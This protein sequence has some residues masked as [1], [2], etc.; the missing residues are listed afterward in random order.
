M[1]HILKISVYILLGIVLLLYIAFLF[2]IP[3]TIDL[4]VYKPQIQKLIK[5]NTDLTLD[6]DKVEVIT[7]P[8]LEGGIKAKNISVNLPDNSTIF[9][10]KSAKGKVFLP[11]LL[12]LNIKVTCAEINSPK[13]NIEIED[14]QQFKVAKVYENL[15]NKQRK[16]RLE[17]N[18]RIEENQAE[19]PIDPAK[20]KL[21]IPNLKLNNYKAVINDTSAKHHLALKGDELKIGYFNG[22]SAKLKT[23]AKLFSDNNTNITANIDI[24]TFI[25]EFS[26]QE[27]EQEDD[28]AIFALPFTNPVS[29]YRKYDLKSNINTKLKIRQD[30]N[31]KKIKMN[32]Y[33]NIE[34]TTMNLAGLQ[35]PES[36]FKLK[37]KD[38][39]TEIDTNIYVTDKEYINLT[40]N[41]DYGKNPYIDIFLKSPQVHFS[42]ILNIAKAYLNTIHIQ[43]DLGNITASGYMLSN[44]H[45]KT[46]FSDIISAGKIIIRDGNISDKNIGLLF[47]DIHANLFFDNNIFKV[48]NTHILINNHPL[49]ISG[50]IDSNSIANFNIVGDKIPLSGLYQVFAPRNIKQKFDLVSGNLSIDSKV[51][52]EIKDIA[53]ILKADL[54]N[55]TFKDKAGT[56]VLANKTAHFGIANYAGKIR[57][58]LVNKGFKF[59]LPQTNAVISDDLFETNIDNKT[60]STNESS[61]K[62]NK[63]SIFKLNATV[64][65]YITNPETKL[66]ADGRFAASDIAI[67]MGKEALPYFDI[68]GTIPVKVKLDG[69]NNRQKLIIQAKTDA[70]NYI[71][72]ITINELVGKHTLFQL[73]LVNNNDT[74]KINKSGIY[75]TSP[76]SGF[77]NKLYKNLAGANP[78]VEIRGII[79]SISTEPFI[80]LLK[81]SIS[82]KLN[83]S[84]CIFKKSKFSTSGNI[85]AFG[86][87]SNPKINGHIDVRD[88]EIPEIHTAIRHAF[89]Q[90]A[91]KNIN[92]GINDVDAN[93]SDF[94]ISAT[95]NLELISKMIMSDIKINSRFINIDKLMEVSNS[96]MTTLPK[97]SSANTNNSH[98]NANIPLE[99]KNG[100]FKFDK[101]KTGDIIANNTTGKLFLKNNILHVNNIKTRPLGGI[102]TGNAAM[103]LITTEL[104]MRLKGHDFDIEKVLADA[105]QMKDTLTGNMNFIADLSLKGTSY[106]EQMKTLKGFVDFNIQDG[107][108]GPFGKFENF[109]MAENIRENAFFS[110]AVGSIITNLVTI[111]TAHFNNLYGHLT[112]KDGLANIEP[113]KSQGNVMSIYIAGK[114]NLLD[115]SADMKLRGKLASAFSDKLGPLAN[116]NPI[117]L[118][119]NTPGLNI[120]AA[121]TFA[122]FCQSVSEEEMKAIPQLAKDRSDENATKFQ[123]ILRGDTRKP[124]KMIK[125]FKWLA[126]DSEIQ[127]A[128]D[129]VDTL[130]VHLEGEE[131]LSVE[132]LIK[133]RQEQ[134]SP[135]QQKFEQSEQVNNNTILKKVKSKLK[136]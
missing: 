61:I 66:F 71:T 131:N 126:L 119:K 43:N 102:V 51:T 90:L 38:Y 112:F 104:K 99:I 1:K 45:F 35:L 96:L 76:T 17:N 124:L 79:S 109:L 22:K 113:I 116:I 83:G 128:R 78:I 44:A 122:I 120:V 37:A 82:K 75:T 14:S 15:V 27:T 63:N 52:G 33:A 36:Y 19:L 118:V 97:T 93:G 94:N 89:I 130:P 42:N 67:F 103:N 117:N 135:P 32:G 115:N 100:S 111:D 70:K 65:N 77:S 31:D 92:I 20:I 46:D 81:I 7:S 30:K 28:E 6:F 62:I 129:F 98:N 88:I 9:F 29:E 58:K 55:F 11:S 40:G 21:Y 18:T 24:D 74:L 107:T 41:I 69:K 110:S 108:L 85:F 72:P 13:L 3:K 68:K 101:I 123:I 10:A 106:E 2:I 136:K 16:E 39:Y 26:P 87:I 47:N 134:T 50:K 84:I 105:M 12:W 121:K 86:K 8:W 127:S 91:T 80:N 64:K 53:A 34:N 132:E 125:S 4:N 25:P 114:L 49:D 5:D 60:I 133:L 54:N 59:T 48:Q 73:I 56:F 95:T 57:G 23:E